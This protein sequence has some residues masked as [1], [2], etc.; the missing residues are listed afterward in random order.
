MSIHKSVR[1]GTSQFTIRRL[2]LPALL[3]LGVF[4]STRVYLSRRATQAG[5][6]AFFVGRELLVVYLTS[7]T[8]P[9]AESSESKAAY[10]ALAEALERRYGDSLRVTRVGVAIDS[11]ARAG[12]ALL[13][14]MG[15]F[16]E[17]SSG[18][19]WHGTSALHYASRTL[20]GDLM[21]PQVVIASRRIDSSKPYETS[22]DSLHVRLLGS[23]MI[24]GWAD[25]VGSSH[26]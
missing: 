4:G 12:I 21:V 20:S 26:R 24:A 15:K 11:D 19:G 3:F 6:R 22:G 25:R 17:I 18:N 7:T 23:R 5:D 9:K 10:A 13:A 8:C 1:K 14:S 16:D 2:L